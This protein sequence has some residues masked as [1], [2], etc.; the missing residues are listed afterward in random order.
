MGVGWKKLR[1]EG[2]R[3]ALG[4]WD[5]NSDLCAH[6]RRAASGR[7]ARTAL[8]SAKVAPRSTLLRPGT[9]LATRIAAASPGSSRGAT[10][11]ARTFCEGKQARHR[12]RPFSDCT[13]T[14]DPLGLFPSLRCVDPPPPL[15]GRTAVRQ[16]AQ[17][18]AERGRNAEQPGVALDCGGK[19]SRRPV[20][21]P[22]PAKYRSPIRMKRSGDGRTPAAG[23]TLE[24]GHFR[25][26]PAAFPAS[27]PRLAADLYP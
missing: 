26:V 18:T 17:H 15:R 11:P 22:P 3:R 19:R 13:S 14:H 25:S 23:F 7:A 8:G 9:R 5:S 12:P 27:R 2:F 4:A 20:R 21:P 6:P 16:P 10:D 24:F 1:C